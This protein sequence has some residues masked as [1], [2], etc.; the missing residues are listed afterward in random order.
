MRKKK[1]S[2]P[3]ARQAKSGRILRAK[4]DSGDAHAPAAMALIRALRLY[5]HPEGGYYREMH[6]STEKVETAKGSRPAM[7]TIY[8]LLA[9]GQKS[10][11]HRVTSDEVWH[12]YA[13]SPLN[14]MRVMGDFSAMER[15]KLGPPGGGRRS[16]YVI[17][18]G[19]WQAAETAGDYSLV[20]CSVGP[21]FDF[22]DFT[23]MRDDAEA[24]A[25]LTGAFPD[26]V[27]RIG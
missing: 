20:G 4:A 17:P 26:M 24:V 13:G 25:R 16:M 7:T 27:K 15:V 23:L 19:Q 1:A 14:L 22:E 10:V 9:K 18:A 12:F 5:P 3:P 6:R 2:R 11:F 8:F 21:G